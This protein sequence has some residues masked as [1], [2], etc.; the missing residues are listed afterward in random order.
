MRER[1]PEQSSPR[2]VAWFMI[3]TMSVLL[4]LGL[5]TVGACGPS[6]GE[7]GT[8]EQSTT[9][10][11]ADSGNEQT[12]TPDEPAATKEDGPEGTTKEDGP[13][14]TTKEDGP[15]VQ[16]EQPPKT[17]SGEVTGAKATASNTRAPL[18]ASPG[19]DGKT[20]FY[21]AYKQANAATTV[22][23]DQKD[24]NEN[25]V[26][27][28]D[29][30]LFSVPA[31]GGTA[32]ELAAGFWSPTG[33]VV[34]KDGSKVY[35]ADSGSGSEDKPDEVGAIYVVDAGGG[36]KTM[37]NGTKGYKPKSLDI[38]ME[39]SEQLY[40]TGVDPSTNKP[41]VFRVAVGGGTVTTV[42][43][44]A[45]GKDEFFQDPGGI[46]VTGDRTIYVAETIG[47][48]GGNSSSIIQ[49]KGGTATEFVMGI[50]VGYPA[51]VA[52]SQDEKFILV[53]GIDRTKG[54]SVLYRIDLS[55]AKK[56]EMITKDIGDNTNSA[57]LH[58]AHNKDIYAWSN[59][60]WP[61]ADGKNGGTVYLLNTKANP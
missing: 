48:M 30:A 27:K 3:G 13:E 38:V 36:T 7:E 29:G 26:E 39:A 21:T 41:G 5:N 31:A 34:S 8:T 17:G 25:T 32:K 4:G 18:D 45:T 28:H 14:G 24:P 6:T 55:D 20:I 56:I 22:P 10:T 51:G 49:I 42:Y 23:R 2:W 46:A 12:T 53:S 61:D 60:S 37:V 57:G 11:V 16:P 47:G 1:N 43:T 50:K 52:L 15:E 33:L 58:R 59:A 40:F 9:E 44:P 35:V 19:P 54:T